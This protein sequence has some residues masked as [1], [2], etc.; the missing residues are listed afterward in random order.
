[1][2]SR[3]QDGLEM[4]YHK[5]AGEVRIRAALLEKGGIAMCERI[6]IALAALSTI[7][8]FALQ[9]WRAWKDY[10]SDNRKPDDAKDKRKTR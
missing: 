8:A 7:A 1:M 2:Q 6:L 3:L 10:R 5:P 9:A 4:P